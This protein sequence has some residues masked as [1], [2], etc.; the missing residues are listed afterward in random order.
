MTKVRQ[1]KEL[2]ASLL[3][4]DSPELGSRLKQRLSAEFDRYSLGA[5][6]EREF[7]TSSTK[8]IDFLSEICSDVARVEREPDSVDIKV[9]LRLDYEPPATSSLPAPAAVERRS[10]PLRNEIWLAFTNPDPHRRRVYRRSDGTIMHYIKVYL[11]LDYEPPATSS[12]PAPA[13]VERRSL[14][15]RN[16]IW[17]AFTN[18]DPHRRRVYR[19]SDGTSMHYEIN[20]SDINEPAFAADDSQL[21]EI[22]PIPAETQQEWMQEF[23]NQNDLPPNTLAEVQRLL[24]EPYESKQNHVFAK[25]LGQHSD[26]WKATRNERVTLIAVEWAQRNRVPIARL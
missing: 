19:R 1:A 2:L 10:L 8:F 20:G 6:N 12:L 21:V 24:R 7:G 11:R 3:S 5:F 15:L 16:E 22:E 25:L 13:A 17:L 9:Y 14:P 26:Q 4:K 23:A 18:P